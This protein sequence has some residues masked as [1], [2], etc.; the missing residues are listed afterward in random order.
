MSRKRHYA[1]EIAAAAAFLTACGALRQA[2]DDMQPPIAAPGAVPRTVASATRAERAGSW[3][4]PEAKSEDLLYVTNLHNVSVY[5]YPAGKLVGTL[6]V[7]GDGGACSN[8]NGNV[9]LMSYR[10]LYEYAH[11]EKK[12]MA[13]VDHSGHSMLACGVDPTTENVAVVTTTPTRNRS[14]LTVYKRGLSGSPRLY[15]DGRLAF[16]FCGYD[17]I[18]DL[19]VTALTSPESYNAVLL[20]MRTGSGTFQTIS[21]NQHLQSLGQVQWD[22]KYLALGDG[23]TPNIYRF[24]ISGRKGT[25]EATVSLKNSTR[26]AQ[27]WIDGGTVV[28][29][30]EY[31]SHYYWH[32]NVLFYKYPSG[33]TATRTIIKALQIPWGATVSYAPR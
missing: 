15:S 16:G 24:A 4:L 8:K 25:L 2:Q 18:G 11:G 3:L 1:L 23:L 19:F 29:P 31:L 12:P 26:E 32:Y 7:G 22:G 33:G 27:W 28:T 9:Y 14:W 6:A 17:A 20:E 30:N 13:T 21:L 5:S 10:Y